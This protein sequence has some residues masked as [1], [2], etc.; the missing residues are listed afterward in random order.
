MEEA[1]GDCTNL[2]IAYPSMVYGFLHLIQASNRA[3]A[4]GGNDVAIGG[5]GA[6]VDSIRRYHDAMSRIAERQ[7]LRNDVSKYEA[8]ALL[9]IRRDS[10]N[11]HDIESYPPSTSK[12]RFVSFFE[13]LYRDY[14]LRYVFAAPKLEKHTRRVTWIENELT[15]T[16]NVAGFEVRLG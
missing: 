12:L 1:A 16:A 15:A 6:P 8:I 11:L 14:D 13:Q 4:K 9:M 7:D 5:G 2:H 10:G 3:E